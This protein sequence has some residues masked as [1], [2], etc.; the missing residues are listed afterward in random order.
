DQVVRQLVGVAADHRPQRLAGDVLHDDPALAP[1][2]H[3]QVVQ[4]NEVGVLEVEAQFD[5]AQFDV[6]LAA[7]EFERDLLAAVADGEVDLAEAA[8]AD[9][10]LQREPVQGPR[11]GT[12]SEAHG[13]TN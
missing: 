3:A 8:A 9:A 7:Q 10:A 6:R 2:V 1:A 5:A 11:S 12:V 4:V 13:N